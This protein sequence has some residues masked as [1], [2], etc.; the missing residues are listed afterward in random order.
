MSFGSISIPHKKSLMS[1]DT[2]PLRQQ[3]TATMKFSFP[4][5]FAVLFVVVVG[6]ILSAIESA[7]AAR[8]SRG[9]IIIITTPGNVVSHL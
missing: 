5:K 4:T 7:D 6:T 3:Y 2:P 8:R 9:P 1:V